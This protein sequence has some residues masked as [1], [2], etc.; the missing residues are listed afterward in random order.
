M[1]YTEEFNALPAEEQVKQLKKTLEWYNDFADCVQGNHS[2]Y[3]YACEYADEK[4]KERYPHEYA[5]RYSSV[6]EFVDN[7]ALHDE[8]DEVFGEDWEAENDIE[9]IQELVN[10][11][12]PDTFI[13]KHIDQKT[14]RDKRADDYIEVVKIAS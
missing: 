9:Q 8:A 13:V 1:E 3:E 11:I 6:N 10:H 4:E 2:A 14:A 5:G 12:V 7:H